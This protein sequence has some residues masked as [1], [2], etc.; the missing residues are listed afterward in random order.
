MRPQE[1]ALKCGNQKGNAG[2]KRGR[3]EGHYHKGL[4]AMSL[5]LI[6]VVHFTRTVEPTFRFHLNSANG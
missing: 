2:D 1:V 3:T 6:F 5:Q 4:F